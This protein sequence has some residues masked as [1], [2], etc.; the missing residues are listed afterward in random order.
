VEKTEL[1]ARAE[2]QK[3]VQFAGGNLNRAGVGKQADVDRRPENFPYAAI[4]SDRTVP[5]PESWIAQ[6]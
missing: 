5:L 2:S 1:S 4:P 3:L 6:L